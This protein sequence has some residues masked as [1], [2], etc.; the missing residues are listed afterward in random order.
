[1][2]DLFPGPT[3]FRLK[4]GNLKPSCKKPD[5][6]YTLSNVLVQILGKEE[7]VKMNECARVARRVKELLWSHRLIL[8]FL[9]FFVCFSGIATA[10]WNPLNPVV[11]VQKEPDGGRFTLQRGVMRL[12]ICS[13]SIIR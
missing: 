5:N 12:Q 6:R 7:R 8:P 9:L 13:D 3:L 10:Q 4:L 11:A 1:M 2:P